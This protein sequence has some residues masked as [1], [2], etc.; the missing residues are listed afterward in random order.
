MDPRT[1][2]IKCLV[3]TSNPHSRTLAFHVAVSLITTVVGYLEEGLVVP[4]A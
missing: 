3:T 4:E 2:L 1:S